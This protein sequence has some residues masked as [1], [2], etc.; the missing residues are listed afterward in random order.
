[1]ALKQ[2]M[3]AAGSVAAMLVVAFVTY[4]VVTHPNLITI[5]T[6]IIIAPPFLIIGL[7]FFRL[8]RNSNQAAPD[9]KTGH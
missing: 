1:M 7:G 2:A 5:L 8:A 4:L 9:H 6:S 3:L